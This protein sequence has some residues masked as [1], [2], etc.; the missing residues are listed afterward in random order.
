MN[1]SHYEKWK[2]WRKNNTNSKFHQLLVLLKLRR[3]LTLESLEM[4]EVIAETFLKGFNGV[5][6]TNGI[7]V[8]KVEDITGGVKIT[9]TGG[10]VVES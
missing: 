5:W 6:P 2:K 7:R 3:S 9:L 1:K 10:E 4:S 8:A